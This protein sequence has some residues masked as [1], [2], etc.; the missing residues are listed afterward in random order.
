MRKNEGA[1]KKVK[2]IDDIW[3]ERGLHVGA[4]FCRF[5]EV[6]P[7]F[8]QLVVDRSPADLQGLRRLGG[9][10]AAF[11]ENLEEELFRNGIE[12]G[13]VFHLCGAVPGR[14]I[15]KKG[16]VQ[17]LRGAGANER[18]VESVLH[19]SDIAGPIGGLEAME[20]FIGQD[21][22]GR[23]I[24]FLAEPL[25]KMGGEK[26]DIFFSIP[27]GRE[28]NLNDL[29]P[30]VKI[31]AKGPLFD[32]SLQIFVGRGDDA[33]IDRGL[34]RASQPHDDLSLEEP[35]KLRLGGRAQFADLVEKKGPL[36]GLFDLSFLGGLSPGEGPFFMSEQLAFDQIEWDG[37][38]VDGDE[39]LVSSRACL[40]DRPGD[41]LLSGPM[42][43][44]DQDGDRMTRDIFDEA[45]DLLHRRAL[46]DQDSEM[47]AERRVGR[48]GL[49]SSI[50]F[51]QDGLGCFLR[52]GDGV[53]LLPTR[54]VDLKRVDP[55]LALRGEKG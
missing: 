15:E 28:E 22:P 37:G 31:G 47:A 19:L 48:G 17:Q 1:L 35:E 13:F 33:G 44:P 49:L 52:N 38:A 6:D 45:V 2:V 41:Q 55:Q 32:C 51:L 14:G 9:I 7:I 42:L 4:S 12:R 50:F 11:F 34:S 24:Q 53:I 8:F 23:Q 18:A 5:A 21:R 3:A 10:P 36:I 20:R 25:D 26:R 30:V 39:R 40:V 43:S 46:S 29:D 27:Q 16:L 54:A